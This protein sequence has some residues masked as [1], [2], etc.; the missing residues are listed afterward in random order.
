MRAV[1][2]DYRHAP[3]D[4][5]LRATLTFLETLTL[6]PEAVGPEDAAAVTAAG[7]SEAAL[8]EA[9]QV[10]VLFNT[11]DRVADA[12]GFELPPAEVTARVVGV[13]L[14]QGYA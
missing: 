6:H 13:L 5:R 10:C 1:L 2:E 12:L 8:E 4:E 9:I 7:V 3:I 14:N 11:I